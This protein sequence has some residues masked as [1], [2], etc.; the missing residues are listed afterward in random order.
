MNT[1]SVL[2]HCFVADVISKLNET[3]FCPKST[4]L[5]SLKSQRQLNQEKI[6]KIVYFF[7]FLL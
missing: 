5:N 7:K 6:K 4:L 2:F 3:G 1:A